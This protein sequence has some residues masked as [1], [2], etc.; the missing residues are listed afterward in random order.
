MTPRV[1]KCTVSACAF[2]RESLCRAPS[3]TV[4]DADRPRCDTFTDN[5]RDVSPSDGTAR[6]SACKVAACRFNQHM[7]C[8]APQISVAMKGDDPMCVTFARAM[9]W[10][11]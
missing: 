11:E 4:G 2:N 10:V 5:G 7:E 1:S 9:A 6:V 3:V 8:G